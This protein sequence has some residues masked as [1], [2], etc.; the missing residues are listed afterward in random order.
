MDQ[1][2]MPIGIQADLRAL[3]PQPGSRFHNEFQT[4]GWLSIPA[5]D[6]FLKFFD[7]SVFQHRR[8]Q[9]REIR[10]LTSPKGRASQSCSFI[11][12]AKRALARATVGCIQIQ[13]AALSVVV[14]VFH[15][16][17]CSQGI[18][19]VIFILPGVM[20]ILPANR[21]RIYFGKDKESR[22]RAQGGCPIVVLLYYCIE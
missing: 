11:A 1:A 16:S 21:S 17:R 18:H 12:Y 13:S 2:G 14:C 22:N 3:T 8:L 6:E 4:E 9:H 19:H 5:P 10:L 7:S 20:L 15:D